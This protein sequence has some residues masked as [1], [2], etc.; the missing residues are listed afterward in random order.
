M[1]LIENRMF[2]N[3]LLKRKKKKSKNNHYTKLL[4]E[5]KIR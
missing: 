1:L 2:R 5:D 3:I 4:K